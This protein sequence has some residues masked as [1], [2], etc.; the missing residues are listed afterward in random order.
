[1]FQFDFDADDIMS[2]LKPTFRSPVS[3]IT[4]C[5]LLHSSLFQA[6]VKPLEEES[7]QENQWEYPDFD[8]NVFDIFDYKE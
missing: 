2:M 1:M 6:A 3:S 5:R 7:I 8:N 4:F